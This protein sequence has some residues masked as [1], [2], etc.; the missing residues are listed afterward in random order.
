M[1]LGSLA[2]EDLD[3]VVLGASKKRE[4]QIMKS[5]LCYGIAQGA[6]YINVSYRVGA[7]RMLKVEE[8]MVG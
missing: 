1:Y 7:C 6:G 4:V 8:V 2:L 3:P 5:E